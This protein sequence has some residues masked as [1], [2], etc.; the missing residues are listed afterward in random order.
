R[1]SMRD[2][3]RSGTGLAH[4]AMNWT[5][6][7]AATASRS[8]ETLGRNSGGLQRRLIGLSSTDA[9][10]SASIIPCVRGHPIKAILSQPTGAANPP[11]RTAPEEAGV[12]P[13]PGVHELLSDRI[14]CNPYYSR[15]GGQ[16]R[17]VLRSLTGMKGLGFVFALTA[18][19][20]LV[21][22]AA[23]APSASIEGRVLGGWPPGPVP[24]A[25]VLLFGSRRGTMTDSAGHFRLKD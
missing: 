9:W 25:N 1:L 22:V 4:A 6:A 16:D 14:W 18:L 17:D 3:S 21:T 8:W 7:K 11:S 10:P 20:F 13:D 23:S 12:C 5:K 24:F 15:L 19:G 2:D